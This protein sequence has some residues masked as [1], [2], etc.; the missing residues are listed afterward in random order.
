MPR[1]AVYSSQLALSI[2]QYLPAK[3]EQISLK[4]CTAEVVLGQG[5]VE[6]FAALSRVQLR[7]RS[8]AMQ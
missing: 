1:Q 6:A 3:L 4:G 7:W 8:K 5:F 2:K